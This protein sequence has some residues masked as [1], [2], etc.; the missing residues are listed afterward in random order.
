[1]IGRLLGNELE[2]LEAEFLKGPARDASVIE[3]YLSKL[4]GFK[5]LNPGLKALVLADAK[6]RRFARNEVVYR[7]GEEGHHY[8]LLVRGSVSLLSRRADFGNF[9]LYLKSYFDGDFFGEQP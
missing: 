6:L 5:P 8:Y 9:E 3:G 1:M 4:R 2:L 7:Q